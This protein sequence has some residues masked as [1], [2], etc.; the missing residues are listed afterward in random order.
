MTE[1]EAKET[2]EYNVL[3]LSLCGMDQFPVKSIQIESFYIKN[4]GQEHDE[5]DL[6]GLLDK[7]KM[8]EPY[9]ASYMVKVGHKYWYRENYNDAIDVIEALRISNKY[10][11]PSYGGPGKTY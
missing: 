8:D 4:E 3:D 6:I 7:N 10:I 5:A 1:K 9:F 11:H 2:I